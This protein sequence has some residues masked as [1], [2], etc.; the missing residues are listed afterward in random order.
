MVLSKPRL[1]FHRRGKEAISA[2]HVREQLEKLAC[3]ESD[4]LLHEQILA[5]KYPIVAV[6]FQE[7]GDDVLVVLGKQAIGGVD[8]P[9]ATGAPT[10]GMLGSNV[11][12]V[13]RQ[14]REPATAGPASSRA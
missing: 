6:F 1:F 8:E 3:F 11:R 9:P 14:R 13:S 2:M 4:S 10:A 7:C 12:E 5:V